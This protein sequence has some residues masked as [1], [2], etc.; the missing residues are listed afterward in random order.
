MTQHYVKFVGY[1]N[2]YNLWLDAAN[3][4]GQSTLTEDQMAPPKPILNSSRKDK[5]T[6][7][8]SMLKSLTPLHPVPVEDFDELFELI[9]TRDADMIELKKSRDPISTELADV[10]INSH[11]S[12]GDQEHEIDETADMD[13][14]NESAKDSEEEN[15]VPNSTDENENEW[16]ELLDNFE[17]D[18]EDA[19]KMDSQIKPFTETG[20]NSSIVQL[21]LSK[22][23][24][25]AC[26]STNAEFAGINE[27]ESSDSEF[28]GILADESE[29]ELSEFEE[30]YE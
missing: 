4:V 25:F 8:T 5:S 28:S 29:T 3:V 22:P 14:K 16:N 12:I 13:L 15:E 20:N 19:V 7:C 10:E 9:V 17:S 1:S 30:G 2:E 27:E 23:H 26:S 24:D 18:I 11:S 21:P 6:M